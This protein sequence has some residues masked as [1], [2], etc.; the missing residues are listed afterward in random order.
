M[1][2]D[3]RFI[4]DNITFVLFVIIIASIIIGFTSYRKAGIELRNSIN[5]IADY[6][7]ELKAR[8]EELKQRIVET[9]NRIASITV[10]VKNVHDELGEISG[11]V[12]NS[13]IRIGA[14]TEGLSGISTS[15]AKSI[16]N[17]ST[18][19]EIIGECLQIIKEIKK[20]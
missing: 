8:V 16:G 20:K 18:A 17:A 11:Q 5:S 10:T 15:I 7:K 13:S 6:N 9:E 12:N 2:E 14:V 19:E 1:N 3:K 4:F